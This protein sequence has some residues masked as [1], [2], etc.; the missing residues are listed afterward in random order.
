MSRPLLVVAAGLAT[1]IFLALVTAPA[2]Y[3]GFA[4]QPADGSTLTSGNPT[5][6]VY[7][8]DGETLPQVEVST[9]AD[10]SDYGFTGGYVGACTPSTPFGEA[11]K[12]TCQLPSFET[13]LAPGTYYWAYTYDK[14]VCTTIYGYTSCY[15]QAQFSGPFKFT[16]APPVA[17]AGAGLVSPSDGAVVGPTPTLTIHAPAGASMEIYAADSA[18]RLSD[19]TPAGG[20]AFSCT[21]SAAS[22]SDYT[23]VPDSP[24]DLQAGQTYYWWVVI[25]VDGMR[26]VYGPRSFTVR[27]SAGGGGGGGGSGAGAPHSISDTPLLP[28]STH[29]GR[30]SVDQTRLAAASY[31]ITKAAGRPKRLGVACWNGIDWPGISGD[32][33]DSYYTELGFYNPAMPHWIHLSPTICRGIETLLYHRPQYPNRILAN[34]VDT[35]THEMIHAI[36]V[37]NEAETEC[38]AM[39]VTLL[40]ALRLGVPLGYSEQLAHL[41]LANYALHPP[42]YVD[43]F[44]CR[45]GG[46][47]D[48]AP[49]QPSPPWHN[50][51]L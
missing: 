28:R 30:R 45:E 33:G 15:P 22:D 10:H 14:N 43:T 16:I 5:F 19:G 37:R 17:P 39:Q 4:V 2:G 42:A 1:S 44:R 40:M 8:D 6:L 12:F 7:I 29:F 36:G 24:Y 27:A 13:P 38:L 20:S 48:I 35:V 11:H 49:N 9:S 23:C 47:W 46:A 41:T 26:W 51:G 21:G 31:W 34:A 25:V 32:P 50:Y 18:D 3:A